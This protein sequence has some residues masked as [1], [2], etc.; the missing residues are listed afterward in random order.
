[1][2]LPSVLLIGGLLASWLVAVGMVPS[3]SCYRRVFDWHEC[4]RRIRLAM[5][6][7][8]NVSHD[9]PVLNVISS[10]FNKSLSRSQSCRRS[11]APGLASDRFCRDR[12]PF[13]MQPAVEVQYASS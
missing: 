13:P 3:R 11:L 2:N 6:L 1:M 12:K 10:P 9:A 5:N 8:S 7:A 4:L